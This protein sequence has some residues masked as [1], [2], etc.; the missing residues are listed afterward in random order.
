MT[1]E[2]HGAEGEQE[3]PEESYD[4]IESH[5]AP[6]DPAGESDFGASEQEPEPEE[7]PRENPAGV[8]IQRSGG[9]RARRQEQEAEE[10]QYHTG[11]I[12]PSDASDAIEFI[13]VHKSFG[14]NH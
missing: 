10:F 13:D 9:A 7:E 11:T 14:R 5:A 6:A 2:Q 1:E 8:G 4:Q 12:R 3:P